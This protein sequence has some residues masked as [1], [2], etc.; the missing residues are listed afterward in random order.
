MLLWDLRA[1]AIKAAEENASSELEASLKAAF[2]KEAVRFQAL[3]RTVDDR[4]SQAQQ[5]V[6]LRDQSLAK[7]LENLET[8]LRADIEAVSE[9]GEQRQ[10]QVVAEM[11]KA[12]ER[13]D[14]DRKRLASEL[15]TYH[16]NDEARVAELERRLLRQ[17]QITH[18]ELGK[19]LEDTVT[20][21]ALDATKIEER[22]LVE[23]GSVEKRISTRLDDC[24]AQLSTSLDLYKNVRSLCKD[25]GERTRN[26]EEAVAE[27]FASLEASIEKKL[28]KVAAAA[29]ANTANGDANIVAKTS[30]DSSQRY[31]FG[32]IPMEAQVAAPDPWG[33]PPPQFYDAS[34]HV[35]RAVPNGVAV[36]NTM[37]STGAGDTAKVT[38][39]VERGVAGLETS[40]QDLKTLV[41]SM[42][43][44]PRKQEARSSTPMA[45][46]MRTVPSPEVEV[47]R[48]ER[49]SRQIRLQKLYKELTRLEPT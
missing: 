25:T 32:H 4:I 3:C 8:M 18:D 2:D 14:A 10:R 45:A 46:T 47:L 23:V 15:Q 49:E 24:F 1:Q 12:V 35:E 26:A 21:Q 42:G 22:V 17:A 11:R 40:I 28:Q 30:G 19:R 9:L 20:K 27:Q 7:G 37:G 38:S 43:T 36:D 31:G 13:G 39:G 41:R 29:A 34:N 48:R 5:E 16:T 33:L 44:P 6:R